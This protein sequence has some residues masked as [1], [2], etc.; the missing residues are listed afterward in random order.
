MF[1][2]GLGELIVILIVALV[3]VG[4]GDLPK[5]A[6]AIGRILKSARKAVRELGETVDIEPGTGIKETGDTLKTLNKELTSQ[7]KGDLK[8][9]L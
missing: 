2:I 4:P 3:I 9:K 6:R 5:V 8:E 1:G 7:L